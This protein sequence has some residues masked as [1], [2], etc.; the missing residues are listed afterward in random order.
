[1]ATATVTRTTPAEEGAA[2]PRSVGLSI[3]PGRAPLESS[4]IPSTPVAA[5]VE[6]APFETGY[7]GIREWSGTRLGG[8]VRG[9]NEP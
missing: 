1:M 2:R 6:R 5:P 8:R 4:S 9:R 7:V 3:W